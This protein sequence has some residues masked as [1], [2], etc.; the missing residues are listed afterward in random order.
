MLGTTRKISLFSLVCVFAVSIMLLCITTLLTERTTARALDVRT[1]VNFTVADAD[2]ENGEVKEIIAGE[3]FT[4]TVNISTD[5]TDNWSAVVLYIGPLDSESNEVMDSDICS[6]LSIT[7]DEWYDFED[8]WD[9]FITDTEVNPFVYYNF[10]SSNFL[11][12]SSSQTGY[13]ALSIQFSKPD[14]T[15][16]YVSTDK[17][18]KIVLPT[19]KVAED[20]DSSIEEFKFGI[21]PIVLNKVSYGTGTV[22]DF[23]NENG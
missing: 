5:R 22:I 15:T 11:A 16:K 18:F 12:G 19:I 20:I 4:I 17:D 14:D 7:Q 10:T 3:E 6:K 1:T 21:Q 9:E 23:A 2:D 8:R 13:Q